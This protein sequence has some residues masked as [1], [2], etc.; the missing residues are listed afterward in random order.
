ML[1]PNLYMPLNVSICRGHHQ[2]LFEYISVVIQSSVKMDFLPQ[3]KKKMK[4][5]LC[6]LHAVCL[7]VYPL[8]QRLNE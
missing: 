4:V 7:Y 8:C 1:S 5:G 2:E 3:F 6:D